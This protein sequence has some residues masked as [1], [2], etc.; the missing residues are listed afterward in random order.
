VIFPADL[1]ECGNPL[2][3]RLGLPEFQVERPVHLGD[4]AF[5]DKNF[6]FHIVIVSRRV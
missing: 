2:G 4:L 3:G 5:A 6:S 1:F